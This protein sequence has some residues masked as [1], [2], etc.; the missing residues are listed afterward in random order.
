MRR[1]AIL[2]LMAWISLPALAARKVSVAELERVLAKARGNSDRKLARELHG[3]ELTEPMTG[4]E[5]ARLNAT[6]PGAKS[7]QALRLVADLSA[8]LEPTVLPSNAASIPEMDAQLQMLTLSLEYVK[9]MRP[10]LPNFTAMRETRRFVEVKPVRPNG[11]DA[12]VTYEPLHSAGDALESMYYRHGEEVADGPTTQRKSSGHGGAMLTTRGVFGPLLEVALV[13]ALR[14]SLT[15]S[16]WQQSGNDPEA[17][18]HFTVPKAKSHYQVQFCCLRTAL[19]PGGEFRENVGYHGEITLDPTTGTVLRLQIVAEM[20]EGAP[21]LKSDILVEY[22]PV[23]IA[24][25]SYFCPVRSVSLQIEWERG[26]G[27][28]QTSLNDVAFTGY[29]MFGTESRVLTGVDGETP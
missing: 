24:G 8:F 23:S 1:L 12:M 6:L 27:F 4:A 26:T 13:D 18:F 21:I 2:L 16:R 9:S 17:V 5:L 19:T 7:I 28:M 25:R 14:G 29:H 11:E 15:W 22:E 3:L 10:R 20:E